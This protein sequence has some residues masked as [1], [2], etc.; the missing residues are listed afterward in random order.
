MIPSAFRYRRAQTV[1][2]ALDLL[3]QEPEAKLLA[4]GQSLLPLMKLRLARPG[5]LVDISRIDELRRFEVRPD[6][7]VIGAMVRYHQVLANAELRARLPLLP[8]AVAVIADPQV[9]HRGT[10]GGSAAHADPASDLAAVFLAADAEFVLQGPQ[11]ERRVQA[12][13]WFLGP[14]MSNLQPDE[15]LCRIEIPLAWPPHQAY[16]KFPHPASGYALAGVAAL[17]SRAPDGSVEDVKVAVTGAGQLPFAAQGVTAALKGQT[18]S[19]QLMREAAERGAADG[20]YADDGPYSAAYRQNLARVMIER[21]LAKAS[22][23]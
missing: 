18:L 15:L 12:R 11:G 14:M 17:V 4:G 16:L 8:Q 21:A 2:E 10:V 13:D 9:R 20:T 23:S 5:T 22:E 3:R 6:R 19:R 7:V 1:A